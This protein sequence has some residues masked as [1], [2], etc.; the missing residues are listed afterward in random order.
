MRKIC[1]LL[2]TLIL[3]ILVAFAGTLLVPRVFSIEPM[4]V[5]SGSMEPTYHVGSI[6][7]VKDCTSD[8]VDVG[9]AITFKLNDTTVVT[10]RVV[11]IDEQAQAYVTKGDA[12]DSVDGDKVSFQNVIGK[13]VFTRPYLGF[14]ASYA[15]SQTGIIVLVTL[16]AAILLLTF[17]PDLLGKDDEKGGDR[18]DED[19]KI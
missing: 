3:V 18:N 11:E 7:Y 12:N 9:D 13:P 19:E 4:A 14:I 8:D 2:S 16:I 5:L 15:T 17:L 1:N 6:V 10:H